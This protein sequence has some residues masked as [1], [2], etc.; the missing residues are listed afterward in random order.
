MRLQEKVHK[1]NQTSSEKEQ[2]LSDDVL[3]KVA[4]AGAPNAGKST[5]LNAFLGSERA[6]VSDIAGTTRDPVHG[7]MKVKLTGPLKEFAN[8]EEGVFERNVQLIDTAG[9]RK[10]KL[11]KENLESELV[12]R[13]LRAINDADIILLLVD[14]LK[15]ITHH[16]RR[17][18]DIAIEKG[19]SIIVCFNKID[20]LREEKKLKRKLIIG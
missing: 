2:V 16:D 8:H 9:I 19:K 18:C 11:V 13:S 15:G 12:Y 4:I 10:S 20:Q 7:L 3:C 6:L 5:L 1:L 14:S 17:L